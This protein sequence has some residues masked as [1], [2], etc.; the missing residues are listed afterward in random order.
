MVAECIKYQFP[1]LRGLIN[2]SNQF[3][4]RFE[5]PDN[6]M[7]QVMK[8]AAAVTARRLLSLGVTELIAERERLRENSLD[9]EKM[10]LEGFDQIE[11]EEG[12]RQRKVDMGET[13]S[14]SQTEKSKKSRG[15]VT[16]DGET[17]SGI[18][19]RIAE[20]EPEEGAKELW[21]RF[22]GELDDRNLTPSVIDHPTNPKKSTYEYDNAKGDR[23]SI[24]FGHFAKLVSQYRT[25]KKQLP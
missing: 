1:S 2:F 5:H 11:K 9:I 25:G 20:A 14:K 4:E 17:I 21:Q 22:F 19:S 8:S 3:P 18:I 24:T 7:Q 13:F 16:D 10:K 6:I 15:K 23:K 12:E